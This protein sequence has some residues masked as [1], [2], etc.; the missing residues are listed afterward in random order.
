MSR[1]TSF[2]LLRVPGLLSLV[3]AAAVSA[4]V[5]TAC[6]GSDVPVRGDG[7]GTG[8]SQSA[9]NGGSASAGEAG[10]D[11]EGGSGM[12]SGGSGGMAG[13]GM[14]V[15]NGGS[16]GGSDCDGAALL[17]TN[18]GSSGCH[19]GAIGT[20]A[21]D[22]ASL[23]EAVGQTSS[24]YA[25]N[26]GSGLLIDDADATQGVIYAKVIGSTCGGQMPPGSPLPAADQACIEDFLEGL[27]E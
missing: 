13:S 17:V 6:A 21:T 12:P 22:E 9:T 19:G 18:C 1:S 24:F 2:S 11:G 27:T 5:V 8:G 15:E 4:A 25:A 16:G 10:S 3:S 7:V 20:F 26:C 14:Q 23:G